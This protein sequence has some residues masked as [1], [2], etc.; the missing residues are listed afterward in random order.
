MLVMDENKLK[1]LKM[2]EKLLEVSFTNRDEI[3]SQYK[4]MVLNIDKD[5][6]DRLI[7]MIKDTNYHNQTLE[8]QLEFLTNLENEYNSFNE[9]QCRYRNIYE[10]YASDKLELSPIEDI[11][12]DKIKERID[13]I[14]GYLIN[15]QNLLRYRDNLEELNVQ[16]IDAEKK[17]SAIEERLDLL[18]KELR[19][20]VLN[21]EGRIDNHGILEYASIVKEFEKYNLS[22]GKILDDSNLLKTELDETIKLL[23]SE[24]DKMDA[25]KVC[26]NNMPN[27]ETK[28]LYNISY[29]DVLNANYK[30]ILLNF[31]LL[32][33]NECS[34]YEE[35]K[36]KRVKLKAL[37]K[38]RKKVLNDLGIKFVVDPFDRIK[39]N[40]QLE[41]IELLGKNLQNVLLVR[42]KIKY[43]FGLVDQ[44]NAK[45][46]ELYILISD[47]TELFNN[48]K[49]VVD[50]EE[51][52]NIQ[53]EHEEVDKRKVIG[54][55]DISQGLNINLIHE[56]TDG[57][58]N[59]VYEL[60]NNVPVVTKSEE[61]VPEL[62][63]EKD[64]IFTDEVSTQDIFEDNNQ[65]NSD[66]FID[67][68][69]DVFAKKDSI[70]T[71]E[72]NTQQ[73]F[74]DNSVD[75]GLFNEI[76]PFQETVL[77]TNKYDDVF[78]NN[79]HERLGQK[80]IEMPEL[81]FESG[82]SV[83]DDSN[84]EEQSSELSLDEQIKALKLVA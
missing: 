60:F 36:D 1:L 44:M 2:K 11:Y 3:L 53:L 47:K 40:E 19:T 56:K 79:N 82:K 67:N 45:N 46:S 41:I 81:F 26:F 68:D 59:R 10:K 77:F 69:Y 38:E 16:L 4:E 55:R 23:S 33:A 78:A 25:A 73:I 54:L 20:N 24:E 28:R 61:V 58:I 9:F 30:L 6:Y 13:A 84:E 83:F 66:L 51:A 43:N 52:I 21:A 27:I 71:D 37:I 17:K 75:K 14:N 48:K 64:S 32:M 39:I 7:N 15:N 35:I 42:E 74:E 5:M 57:V 22:L 50:D 18:E 63:I 12:I 76:E 29:F 8:G 70:F 80:D 72:V 31:A 49:W 34:E 62:L 65:E